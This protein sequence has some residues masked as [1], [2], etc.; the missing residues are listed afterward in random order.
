VPRHDDLRRG[1]GRSRGGSCDG[2]IQHR[3]S[4]L[5]RQRTS[6]AHER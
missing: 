5:A 2:V 4:A 3:Q 6:S 1:S